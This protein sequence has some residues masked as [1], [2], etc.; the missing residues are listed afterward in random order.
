M[1]VVG[2]HDHGGRRAVGR[3]RVRCSAEE[4][5]QRAR[6]ARDGS[7]GRP[8]V[9]GDRRDEALADAARRGSRARLR[10]GARDRARRARDRRARRADLAGADGPTTQPAGRRR[11]GADAPTKRPSRPA[12]AI[13]TQVVSELA[14][15]RGRGLQPLPGG[16]LLLP[17][18]RAAR[19]SRR[20]AVADR[21][22]PRA[23][24][25][26]PVDRH[27]CRSAA[28]RGSSPSA[29]PPLYNRSQI[30]ALIAYISR[31]GGPPAPTADPAKGRPRARAARVHAA[32]RG[33]PPVGRAGRPHGR[34]P[35]CPTS[36]SA[37]PQQIAEAVRMGPYLM[38]HFDANADRPARARLDRRATCCGRGIPTT[39]AAGG[40][41]TSGRSRRGWSPGSSAWPRW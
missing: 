34:A 16:L 32:L 28:P 18:D 23:G 39:P 40:S 36:T 20:R 30:D 4:R 2:E 8:T 15:A 33:L 27:G 5:R 10:I 22:R 26:L 6:D 24:R 21:G 13:P 17:R 11:S 7:P 29:P 1:W 37:T 35:S 9:R 38:P 14:G 31:F 25:L 41:T 3:D 12:R 19:H